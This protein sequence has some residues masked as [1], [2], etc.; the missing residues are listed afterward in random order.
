MYICKYIIF[1]S[2]KRMFL[3]RWRFFFCPC[4][5]ISWWWSFPALSQTQ[6][7]RLLDLSVDATSLSRAGRCGLHVYYRQQQNKLFNMEAHEFRSYVVWAWRFCK[8]RYEIFF[9]FLYILGV[10]RL[11]SY[12]LDRISPERGLDKWREKNWTTMPIRDTPWVHLA[13]LIYSNCPK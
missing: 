4:F 7:R 11:F 3:S 13:I 10:G 9:F 12:W 8:C 6:D 1:I 5:S 2:L